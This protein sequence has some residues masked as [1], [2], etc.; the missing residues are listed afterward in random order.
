VL[1]K[2]KTRGPQVK[3]LRRMIKAKIVQFFSPAF[4]NLIESLTKVYSED[5]CSPQEGLN[6]DCFKAGKS[7]PSM[8]L[9]DLL[10]VAVETSSKLDKDMELEKSNM[11]MEKL[12]NSLAIMYETGERW[13]ELD[14]NSL[15]AHSSQEFSFA[16]STIRR[17][18]LLSLN[19][20]SEQIVEL[21]QELG[22]PKQMIWSKLKK[23][24]TG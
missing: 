18:K 11:F 12:L 10:L 22:C 3:L 6:T 21:S 9:I 7:K 8:E 16:Y 1:A 24:I 14:S 5:R 4:M 20:E 2:D 13:Y 17:G 23:C 15:N 19:I